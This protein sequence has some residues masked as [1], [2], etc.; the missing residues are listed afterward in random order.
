[1]EYQMLDDALAED[2][3]LENHRTGSFYDVMPPN[4]G[5]KENNPQANGTQFV[6]CQRKESGTLAERERRSSNSPRAIRLTAAVAKEQNLLKARPLSIFKWRKATSCRIM[7]EKL[8]FQK[9]QIKHYNK[10]FNS[11]QR[12]EREE[13]LSK[14]RAQLRKELL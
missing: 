2:N 12:M 10:P 14:D 4:D 7:V 8:S 9:H 5:A 6:S 11:H 1:M 13:T 3:K